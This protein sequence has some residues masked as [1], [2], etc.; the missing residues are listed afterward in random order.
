MAD[1]YSRRGVVALAGAA[2]ASGCLSSRGLDESR[3]LP[4][5]VSLAVA[6]DTDRAH[7]YRVRVR[8]AS[9]TD[10]RLETV[11]RSR[12]SIPAR[13][14]HAVDGDWSKDPGRYA[15]DIS[16]DGGDRHSQDITERL[17]QEERIC[18]A[19]ELSIESDGVTF[20]TNVDAPCPDR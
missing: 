7:E 14:R 6:N 12:G 9:A 18:Y 10:G 4:V 2:L 8:Y 16:V 20:P 3:R 15:V 1:S 13:E 19:Q 5:L 11:F 17:T